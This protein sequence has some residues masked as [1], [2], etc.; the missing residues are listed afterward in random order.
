MHI[1]CINGYSEIVRELINY[2][3]PMDDFNNCGETPLLLAA[4]SIDGE[5]CLEIL[6]S[7]GELY[8]MRHPCLTE[9]HANLTS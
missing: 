9:T 7:E 5:G 3:A 8:S 2:N 4:A 1:A 6:L